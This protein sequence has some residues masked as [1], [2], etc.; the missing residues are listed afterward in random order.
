MDFFAATTLTL[1]SMSDVSRIPGRL[2]CFQSS[3]F[4]VAPPTHA[5]T[6]LPS[7]PTPIT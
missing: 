4:F 7:G 1:V 2:S 5:K 3:S 6:P